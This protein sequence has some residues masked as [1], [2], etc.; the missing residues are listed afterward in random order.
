VTPEVAVI[1][2][3]YNGLDLTRQCLDSLRAS[4]YSS[5]QV[6]VVDNASNDGTPAAIREAYPEVQLLAL[7]E[8]LGYAGGNNAGIRAAL[9]QG[10]GL[11][12]LVNNDTCLYP[13]CIRVLVRALEEHPRA[14]MVGPMVYTWEGNVISSAGGKL[15][16]RNADAVNVGMGEVDG[17]QFAGRAVDFVNGCGLMVTR[18]AIDQAGLLDERFFM[19]WEETEWAVR[20]REAGLEVW[21]EPRARMRHRAPIRHEALSPTTL[22][23]MTRNR[24]FFM[25]RH[26]PWPA[27][28]VVFFRAVWGAW[29][30]VGQLRQGG[31]LA[32]SRAVQLAIYHAFQRR[33]GKA[34]S[35]LWRSGATDGTSNVAVPRLPPDG[36]V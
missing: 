4:D 35:S 31:R 6:W 19:Y 11:V 9:Q 1:I 26:A 28:P 22:Y 24:L 32:H 14:G 29:R 12:F 17:G 36:G 33:W 25:A 18:A 21:F 23:Y 27:K 7:S 10:A 13:D 15:V 2:L 20:V 34:E 5:V 16:W 8:N 3:A 30:G